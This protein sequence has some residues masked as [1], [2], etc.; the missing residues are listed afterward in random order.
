[1]SLVI[2]PFNKSSFAHP[3]EQQIVNVQ[4]LFIPMKNMGYGE[5]ETQMSLKTIIKAFYGNNQN[6]KKKE[7]QE[8]ERECHYER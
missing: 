2:F 1:M 4:K 5:F 3:T 6:S 7:K 8:E